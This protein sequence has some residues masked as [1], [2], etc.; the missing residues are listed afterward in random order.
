ML[1][2]PHH[3]QTAACTSS[4]R[5]FRRAITSFWSQLWLASAHQS[6]QALVEAFLEASIYPTK[7]LVYHRSQRCS[8]STREVTKDQLSS[9]HTIPACLHSAVFAVSCSLTWRCFVA[10]ADHDRYTQWPP[11][12]GWTFCTTT[13][14]PHPTPAENLAA[15]GSDGL[16][17][18]NVYLHRYY[19]S[20]SIISV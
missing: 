17:V 1:L 5:L 15:A 3:W 18:S 16:S 2:S 7:L 10:V 13:R 9:T 20:Y 8:M 19:L 12:R 11:G 14:A 6:T 4:T